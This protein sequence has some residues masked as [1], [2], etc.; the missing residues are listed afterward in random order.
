MEATAKQRELRAMLKVLIRVGGIEEED[1]A[2]VSC[3]L[4]TDEQRERLMQFMEKHPEAG[5]Q[6]IVRE[7][8]EIT[9][10]TWETPEQS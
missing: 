5:M 6:E 7:T 1:A 4:K 10:A 8:L 3:L 2:M 9:E